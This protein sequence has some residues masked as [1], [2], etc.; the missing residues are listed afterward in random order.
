M[1]LG[2][3]EFRTLNEISGMVKRGHYVVLA[4]QPCSQLAIRAKQHGL[5]VEEVNMSRERWL[6]LIVVFLKIIARH[7]IQV[8]NSHG[9]IDSWTA[10]IAGRFSRR[11]PLIVRTR[12]KSTKISRT[13]RHRVLYQRLPHA[14]ITT[15]EAVKNIVVGQ[16][17]VPAERVFSIPTGVDLETFRPDRQGD[18]RKAHSSITV[19]PVVIGTVAF[20]RSYKGLS[21][22]LEAFRMVA[23]SLPHAMLQLV[24]DGPDY[25]SIVK[26]RDELGLEEQV[27]LTGFQED[28]ASI[29]S[30]LDVF[31]LPSIEAEGV[32]QSLTQAMAMGGAV[33][34]TDVGSVREVVKHETTGLLVEAKNSES[35]A[36]AIIR[37]ATNQELREQLGQAAKRHIAECYSF[38]GML[39]RTE[40]VYRA[41]LERQISGSVMV[42]DP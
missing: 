25:A 22:L 17:D 5:V 6:W 42:S 15:G 28:V 24:G 27:I 32:P 41:C 33:V 31:V 26:K 8:V 38:H 19:Q 35:L 4:V 3:Q 10:A 20:F 16:A 23:S 29:L 1:E 21:Y 12:H 14:V 2:G 13:W 34:A 18:G 36:H 11:F 7:Q 40:S 39:V 9:S 37:L 30:N